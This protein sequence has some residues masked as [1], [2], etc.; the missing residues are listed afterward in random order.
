MLL[1][2]LLGWIFVGVALLI[3]SGDVVMAFG[4]GDMPALATGDLWVMLGSAAPVHS[5]VA[6]LLLA[7]PAWLVTGAVGLSLLLLCRERR[8]YYFRHI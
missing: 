1:G 7:I 8:R 2:R 3:G 4:F 6:S 5:T